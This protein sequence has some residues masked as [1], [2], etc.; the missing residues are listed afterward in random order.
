MANWPTFAGCRFFPGSIIDLSNMGL[1]ALKSYSKSTKHATKLSYII[2]CGLAPYFKSKII[3]SLSLSSCIK[4]DFVF[5]FD[6]AFNSAI[7]LKQLDVQISY[8]D[9]QENVVCRNYYGSQFLGHVTA[10]DQLKTFK[11]IFKNLDYDT[12]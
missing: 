3:Q 11:T 5:L 6:E 8:F 10:Q 7:N 4:P 12:Y 2:C 9:N 1:E